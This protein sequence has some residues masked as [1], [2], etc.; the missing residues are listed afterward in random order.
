MVQWPVA[1]VGP[2]SIWCGHHSHGNAP[3]PM[4]WP[5]W[6]RCDIMAVAWP[7][8]RV[9]GLYGC[10]ALF[11]SSLFC[12][13]GHGR[14]YYGHYGC[15]M[16]TMAAVQPLW[17]RFSH[18][19]FGMAIMAVAQSLWPW[20]SPYGCVAAPMAMVQPLWMWCCF[21]GC[22]ATAMAEFRP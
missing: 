7:L 2:P 13:N 18:H 17:Q 19:E 21:Y 12:H 15:S 20:C 11:M 6:P 9:R 1:T 10:G 3:I 14:G 5:L 8:W 4:V 16:T 22:C